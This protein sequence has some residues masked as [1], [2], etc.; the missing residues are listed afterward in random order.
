MAG[1]FDD[2]P[3]FGDEEAD[4]AVAEMVG[5]G[6]VGSR[7]CGCWVEYFAPPASPGVVGPGLAVLAGEH[8]RGWIGA[9]GCEAPFGEVLCEGSEEVNGAPLPGFRGLDLAEGDGSFDED[10]VVA[11]VFAG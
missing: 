2:G 3:A 6:V 11:D 4:V 8:E 1:D 10:R 9:S 7:C 5:G